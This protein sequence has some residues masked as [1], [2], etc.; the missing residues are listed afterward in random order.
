MPYV[1]WRSS[2]ALIKRLEAIQEAA[3]PGSSALNRVRADIRRIVVDDHTEKMIRGVDR[4]GIQR[5]ALAPST[6]KN[7]RRGPGPS[8]IPRGMQSRFITNFQAVW[9]PSGGYMLLT[10]RFTDI[11]SKRGKQFAHYH[12]L[13]APRAHL[14]RRDVGGIT[15]KGWAKIAERHTQYAKD[16]VKMGGGR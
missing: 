1:Q 8:L 16:L 2:P 11:L 4:Y 9:E 7:K 12:L 5:V 14:P 13:G 3:R 10:M 15:P 6:L